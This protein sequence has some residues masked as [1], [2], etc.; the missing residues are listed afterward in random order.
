MKRIDHRRTAEKN[1]TVTQDY[2]R[3]QKLGHGSKQSTRGHT[4]QRSLNYIN[5]GAMR[6]SPTAYQTFSPELRIRDQQCE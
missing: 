1:V 3:K 2:N 4:I 5:D 6:N